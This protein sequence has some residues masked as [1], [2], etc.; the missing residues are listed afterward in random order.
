MGFNDC[1]VLDQIIEKVGFGKA[2]EAFDKEQ[3]K[4]G[5]AIADLSIKNFDKLANPARILQKLI[6]IKVS[7]L[8]PNHYCSL[9]RAVFYGD[10][11][12]YEAQQV[13]VKNEKILTQLV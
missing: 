1:V 7:R 13:A 3:K 6:E 10:Y 2:F 11:S 12:Y 9:Y 4:N 5:D 8:F